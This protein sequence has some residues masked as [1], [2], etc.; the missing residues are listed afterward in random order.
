MLP[1]ISALIP[2]LYMIRYKLS[3]HRRRCFLRRIGFIPAAVPGSAPVLPV[4]P[5]VP[6]PDFPAVVSQAAVSQAAVQ[7]E[8]P[9]PQLQRPDIH[10]RLPSMPYRYP[11]AA[12]FSP[13]PRRPRRRISRAVTAA[14]SAP[15]VPSTLAPGFKDASTFV[16]GSPGSFFDS[17]SE[18]YLIVR[19]AGRVSFHIS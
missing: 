18:T 15:T 2:S 19:F 17:V 4:L 14:H 10:G 16:I 6:E 5:S 12:R 7:P 11:S 1:Q 8:P 9:V 13:S 3:L